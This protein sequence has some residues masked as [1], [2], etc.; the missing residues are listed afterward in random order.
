V[1]TLFPGGTMILLEVMGQNI[2]FTPE[3]GADPYT[4]AEKIRR[5]KIAMAR[6]GLKTRR[7]QEVVYPVCYRADFSIEKS[8]SALKI[9]RIVAKDRGMKIIRIGAK[10]IK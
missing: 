10:E 2:L 3:Q 6:K 9:I 7:A 1:N 5:A 4:A 8:K